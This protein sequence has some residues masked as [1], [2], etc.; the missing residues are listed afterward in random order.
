MARASQ[1]LILVVED[2]CL[3]GLNVQDALEAAGFGTQFVNC[4]IEATALL[5]AEDSTFAGLVTDIRLGVAMTGWDLALVARGQRENFPVVYM[6]GDSA[7]DHCL[8][9]VPNS[10]M[11]QK[12]FD[13][14][15]IV[16]AMSALLNVQP[17]LPPKL[18]DLPNGSKTGLG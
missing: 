17:E 8:F 4:P 15:Q 16:T 9:G 14:C 5:E 7:Q 2:E 10:V 1:L 13:S 3:I 11:V 6:S 18:Q 12:P